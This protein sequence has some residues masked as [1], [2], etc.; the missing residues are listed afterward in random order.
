[1]TEKKNTERKRYRDTDYLYASAYIKSVEDRGLSHGLI[2]RML[3]APDAASAEGYLFEAKSALGGSVEAKDAEALCDEFVNDSFRTVSEV[4]TDPSVFDFM[5]YQYDCNNIKTVLKCRARGISP[6]G[7]LFSCG[8]VPPSDVIKM[9]YEGDFSAL[10]RAFAEAAKTAEVSY[11]KTGDPQSIDLPLDMA[12]LDAMAEA[13]DETG[14]ALLSGA[15]R[16]R[17]D[18]ANVMTALRV[19][20]MGSAYSVS[21]AS[22]SAEDTTPER[23]AELL[24]RALSPLGSIPKET[25]ISASAESEGALVEAV[26]GKLPTDFEIALSQG[27][28]R[29]G[30][31]RAADDAYLG[32]VRSA[33]N[34][35]FGAEV[36]FV[37][38]TE[39]EYNA[40][41]A[42]IIL[43]G[44]KAGLSDD[45][46]R[47]RVRGM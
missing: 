40:K 17:I 43:A 42:R 3:D 18:L 13:A 47:E 9:A 8:T 35:V 5:R 32:Y 16:L 6:E 19:I 30:I 7:M 33:K 41:N 1:M 11:G 38:L 22:G 14:D 26:S 2:S 24:G 20:R 36:P 29:S 31:E 46:I 25:I 12:C 4:V 37:F 28:N 10:P 45:E 44:K 15:V 27:G 21:A 23:R 39:R 34:T